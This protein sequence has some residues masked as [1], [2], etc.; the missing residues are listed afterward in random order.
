M[1]MGA[2][3]GCQGTA[4]RGRAVHAASKPATATGTPSDGSLE[5]L[6]APEIS[7]RMSLAMNLVTSMTMEFSGVLQSKQVQVK[8]A[9]TTDGVCA[10]AARLNGG[11]MQ[12]IRTADRTAYIKGDARYWTSLSPKGKSFGALAANRWIRF[13]FTSAPG[14]RLSQSCEVANVLKTLQL[15]H[16]SATK[17]APATVDGKPVVTIKKKDRQGA[18]T[19]YVAAHGPSYLLKLTDQTGGTMTFGSFGKPVNVEAPP[20]NQ[21]IDFS[22]LGGDS[23]L[24]LNA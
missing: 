12:I 11:T 21:T 4:D 20:A 8:I 14:K 9:A 22:L 3:S 5:G 1:A 6:T 18:V 2:L 7:R 23:G 17:G 24:G 13:P 16:E 19:Y 10:A 15:A